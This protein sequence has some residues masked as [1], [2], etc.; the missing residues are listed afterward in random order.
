VQKTELSAGA[1]T[2]IM[3]ATDSVTRDKI[4]N[5]EV[6]AAKLAND[7]PLSKLQQ[8]TARQFIRM[9]AD[10]SVAGYR[11]FVNVSTELTVTAGT[12]EVDHNLGGVPTFFQAVLVCKET[13][14]GWSPGDELDFAINT[15]NVTSADEHQLP[16]FRNAT[17]VGV[18]VW[19]GGIVIPHKTTFVRV[20]ADFAK[21]K[22]KF[23]FGR[24]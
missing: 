4:K 1:V 2:E 19:S 7:L 24:D 21:W 10:G 14:G 6:V 20:G 18:C 12:I 17:K 9:A 5:G 13:D 16:I 11:S 22:L 15:I 8:G 23:Y 3:L